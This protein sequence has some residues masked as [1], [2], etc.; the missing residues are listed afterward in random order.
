MASPLAGIVTG[1]SYLL[2]SYWNI[3]KF[4]PMLVAQTTQAK[5]AQ[6]DLGSHKDN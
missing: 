1:T 2:L 4:G 3:K 6:G 5:A